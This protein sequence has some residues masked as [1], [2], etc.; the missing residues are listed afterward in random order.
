MSN[1]LVES[2]K[3]IENWNEYSLQNLIDLMKGLK[4]KRKEIPETPDIFNLINSICQRVIEIYPALH[5]LLPLEFTYSQ[6]DLN[7]SFTF[8]NENSSKSFKSFL[9][10]KALEAV[11]PNDVGIQRYFFKME[12][13]DVL[14]LKIKAKYNDDIKERDGK[15]ASLLKIKEKSDN[16]IASKNAKIKESIEQMKA[17]HDDEIKEKDGKI[18][19]LLK[20]K[21]K[22]DNDIASK[23]AKIKES[24]EQMK[25][26]HDDEIKEK[27]GKIASKLP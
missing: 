15:I 4:N 2:K 12:R 8:Q 26:K 27:D 11:T 17:K 25:A 14:I 13:Q 20:I 22:S 18:A 16:D 1:K 10:V 24:I 5:E 9:L 3:L 19:S 6:E 21:E 23:N 7:K